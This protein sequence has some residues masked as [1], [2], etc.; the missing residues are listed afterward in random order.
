[1]PAGYEPK[2]SFLAE[3]IEPRLVG[4][5]LDLRGEDTLRHARLVELAAL[6]RPR[7][8]GGDFQH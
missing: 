6:G 7:R 1:M 8:A 2:K 4:R 5:V 3:W